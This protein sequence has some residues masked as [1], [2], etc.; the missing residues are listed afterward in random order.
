[1][2]EEELGGSRFLEF[3]PLSLLSNFCSCQPQGR[4]RKK[5]SLKAPKWGRR[6]RR[7]RGEAL[8][9]P[10][11]QQK[12]NEIKGP[13]FPLSSSLFLGTRRRRRQKFDSYFREGGG[14][15]ALRRKRRSLLTEK[16][17]RRRRRRK[18]K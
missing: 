1:M 12:R 17:W 11:T 15:G 6:R 9:L 2:R 5:V 16:D 13:P 3:F 18:G 14:R 7:G 4:G 8:L 10:H